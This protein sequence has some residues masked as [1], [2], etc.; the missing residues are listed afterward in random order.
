[1]RATSRWR[2]LRIVGRAGKPIDPR[3]P[4]RSQSASRPTEAH[5]TGMKWRNV[6]HRCDD[7][8]SRRRSSCSPPV[9]SRRPAVVEQWPAE[10]RTIRSAAASPITTSTTSSGSFTSYTGSSKGPTSAAR[11]DFPGFGGLEQAGVSPGLQGQA[12]TS[13]DSG[14]AGFYDSGAPRR[15]A[16]GADAVGRLVGERLK[17]FMSNIDRLDW[18]G[19]DHRRRRPAAEPRHALDDDGARRARPGWRGSRFRPGRLEP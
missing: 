2:S 10:S 5:A 6:A 14:I 3:S 9:R 18:C 4:M 16:W 11:L 1:M 12:L 17:R 19:A 13:S 8:R 7:D 15:S